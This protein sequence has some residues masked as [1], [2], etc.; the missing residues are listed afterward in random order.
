MTLLSSW[1][2][3]SPLISVCLG[4]ALAVAL[5]LAWNWDARETNIDRAVMAAH[6]SET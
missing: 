2:T 1:T 5:W 6:G 3:C 4:A